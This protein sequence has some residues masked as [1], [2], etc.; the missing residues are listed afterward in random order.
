MLTIVL[1]ASL[2]LT[3]LL[4]STV[5][6]PAQ[7][8][9][10]AKLGELSKLYETGTS[11]DPGIISTVSGDSGGKSYGTYMF[12]SNAGTPHLFAEWLKKNYSSTSLYYEFGAALDE[13]YHTVSDGYGAFFDA[14]WLRLAREHK[15]EFAAAQ[16]AY[17][18]DKFYDELVDLV[19]SGVR[20]FD[21]D[22]Y[23]IALKNVFW[24]RAVQHGAKG[25]YNVVTR[26]FST[27]GGFTGQS[28]DVLIDAIYAE[29]SKLDGTPAGRRM[30]GATAEKYGVAGESMSYYSAN[31]GGVQMSV[32]RRLAVNERSDALV[33]HKNN[34]Y[35]NSVVADGSYH[36]GLNDNQNHTISCDKNGNVSLGGKAQ[37]FVLRYFSGGFYTIETADGKLRLSADSNGTVKCAAPA[38]SDSQRWT[39]E[40][41]NSGYTLKNRATGKYLLSTGT[42]LTTSPQKQQA[43]ATP[44]DLVSTKP[45]VWRL[46]AVVE[47]NSDLTVRCLIYP[48]A[49]NTIKQ[50]NAS[51]PV[52]GVISCSKAIQS[53]TLSVANGSGFSKTVSPNAVFYDLKKL[54]DSIAYSKLTQ[55]N[56]TYT[57]TVKVDGKNY[58]LVSSNFTVAEPDPEVL[59]NDTFTVTFDAGGG[60]VSPTSKTVK[61]DDVVYGKL[62]TPKFKDHEFIGWFT[63][64]GDQ[65]VANSQVQA[66]DI[67][68]YARYAAYYTYT[69]LDAAGN[70]FREGTAATGE[71]IPAPNKVPVKSPQYVFSHWEGYTENATVM[72]EKNV[73]FAPVFKEAS[74]AGSASGNFWTL[75]M[76]TDA[77]QLG[78]AVYSGSNKVTSGQVATGMTTVVE[79]SDGKKQ[80]YVIVVVGDISG[81]GRINITDVVRLQ[82]HLLGKDSLDGAYKSAADLND[83]GKVSITDLVKAARVVVGKDS[84]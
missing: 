31:S 7:S 73:T 40:K 56:Y 16:H 59:P 13:A 22:H 9:E 1:T 72:G 24:S 17:V 3:G 51:F 60:T 23:S 27:L 6:D 79:G 61:L 74:S 43:L 19:E 14:E 39:L 77:S 20:G 53:V 64:Y 32:Y 34:G 50:N 41:S 71:L 80:E 82:A 68:L 35:Y 10:N 49:S 25:A 44:T 47:G 21:I 45:T 18:Q 26:A 36:I 5:A 62:P 54:D 66:E 38:S 33:M 70:V 75:G 58:Q 83:D 57:L 46:T 48:G 28:E 15:S 84:I 63:Q 30:S 65:I 76:G 81:D 69:F 4:V 55:G 12:A 52:R 2:L 11:S 8:W 78:S 67:T 37:K 29:C 42:G